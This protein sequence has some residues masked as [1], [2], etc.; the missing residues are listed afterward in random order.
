MSGAKPPLSLCVFMLWTGTTSSFHC[1]CTLKDKIAYML[2]KH[3]VEKVYGDVE[4][5]LHTI[6]MWP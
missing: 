4:V 5:Y 3:Q 2:I 1:V 6:L